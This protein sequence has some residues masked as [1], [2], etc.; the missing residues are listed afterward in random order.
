[1]G[2]VEQS[3]ASD[4]SSSLLQRARARDPQAWRRLAELYGPVAYGWL[5]KAGF[6]QHDAA[7]LVQETFQAVLTSL[8]RFRREKPTDSFRSWLWTI[9]RRKACDLWRT[10]ASLLRAAGGDQQTQFDQIPE[11]LQA[12]EAPDEDHTQNGLVRRALELVRPEF[13]EHTWT[14]CIETAMNGRRP[15]DV[16]AD[17]NM[18]VGAVYVARSRVLKRL[19]QELEGL[20]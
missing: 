19:R 3:D 11:P 16:A 8:D 15:A 7:D 10:R 18:T 5:R 17:L 20:L 13:A 2:N 1:M 4:A 9:L 14:A 6:Q 12:A